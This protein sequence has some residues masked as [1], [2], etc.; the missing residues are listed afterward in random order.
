MRFIGH[1]T[2]PVHSPN[3][4]GTPRVS[5]LFGGDGDEPADVGMVIVEVPPGAG[6]PPHRHH[7]SD[8]IL[9]PIR[10]AV[11]VTKDEDGVDVRVGDALLIDKDEAVGLTN[12]GDEV[13]ELIV[14]AGPPAFVT[15]VSRWPLAEVAAEPV[16]PR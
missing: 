13:A 7:G 3:M 6:M 15:T 4:P 14:A 9:V 10:G 2:A 16:T 1:G 5:V 8:V 11:R 12:T